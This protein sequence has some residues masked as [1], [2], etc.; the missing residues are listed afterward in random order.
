VKKNLPL[1][2]PKNPVFWAKEKRAALVFPEF[3][4]EKGQGGGTMGKASLSLGGVA[5]KARMEGRKKRHLKKY[6]QSIRKKGL[7]RGKPN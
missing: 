6:F 3:Q 5:A 7:G 4:G 1:Y 2:F